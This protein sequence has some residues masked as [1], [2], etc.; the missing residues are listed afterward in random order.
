LR[1]RCL[2][3][4][5]KFNTKNADIITRVCSIGCLINF[6]RKFGKFD[7]AKRRGLVEI[8]RN[9]LMGGEFK[10][11]LNIKFRSNWEAN[12]A[13]WLKHGELSFEYEPLTFKVGKLSYAP[14]FFVFEWNCFPFFFNS[15]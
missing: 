12:F 7:W 13:R 14:D 8:R 2:N 15:A 1:I 9:R 11:D 4:D 10:G 6:V 5:G 3:C